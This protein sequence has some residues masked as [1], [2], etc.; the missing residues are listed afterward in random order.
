[1]AAASLRE[2]VR[3]GGSGGLKDK[4]NRAGGDGRDSGGR[5]GSGS[6]GGA[7]GGD[8]GRGPGN[9]GNPPRKGD[10]TE[11]FNNAA[12]G[13]AQ[14]GKKQDKPTPAPSPP[15]LNPSSRRRSPRP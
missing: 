13:A 10:L 8:N 2:K 15:T 1:M 11:Q 7:G 14:N 12:R 5:R 3:T 4:F 6:G 9:N